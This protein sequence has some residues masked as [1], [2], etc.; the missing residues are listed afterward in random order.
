MGAF[1][2]PLKN[3][4]NFFHKPWYFYRPWQLIRGLYFRVNP[5]SSNHFNVRTSFGLCIGINPNKAIGKNIIFNGVFDLAVSEVLMRLITPGDLVVDVGANVGYMTILASKV[6][7][8]RGKVFS[9]EPHPD[10]FKIL[11]GNIENTTKELGYKNIQASKMAIGSKACEVNLFVPNEFA[12][13]DGICRVD[14]GTSGDGLNIKVNMN[15]ID[16]LFESSQISLLKIDVEGFEE[17]VLRGA[18]NSLS[19]KNIRN[20]VFEEHYIHDSASIRL[21]HSYGYHIF[22][23]GWSKRG[24]IIAPIENNISLA[25]SYESPNYIATIEPHRVLAQCNSKGWSV[26]RG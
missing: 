2:K 1:F 25:K 6:T 13:N 8:S 4:M 22:S 18:E 11:S 14:M 7:G 9:F 20:L 5:P 23:L 3:M 24:L 19:K 26:L 21:L 15:S 17:Q 10:L 16:N 12:I